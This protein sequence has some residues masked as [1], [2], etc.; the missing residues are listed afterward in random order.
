MSV[1]Y[2][3]RVHVLTTSLLKLSAEHRKEEKEYHFNSDITQLFYEYNVNAVL[4]SSHLDI[5][6]SLEHPGQ[7]VN[8]HHHVSTGW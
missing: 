1:I 6:T 4:I 2:L 3:Q 8:F 7:I 5:L